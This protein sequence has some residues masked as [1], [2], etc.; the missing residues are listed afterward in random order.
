MASTA[1]SSLNRSINYE[2][3]EEQM[4]SLKR[5]VTV[6]MSQGSSEEDERPEMLCF[7][8]RS[9]PKI[10]LLIFGFGALVGIAGY[11]LVKDD[12]NRAHR[13]GKTEYFRTS[14]KGVSISCNFE[15]F[16]AYFGKSYPTEKEYKARKAIFEAS[17]LEIE[18]IR[19]MDGPESTY[20]LELNEFADMNGTEF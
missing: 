12:L 1:S 9:L 15:E 14:H 17:K 2:D 18:R 11:F 7:G 13:D 4:N 5:L 16:V 6:D 8:K 20:S 19:V 10:F 3:P